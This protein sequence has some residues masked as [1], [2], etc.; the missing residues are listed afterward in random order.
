MLIGRRILIQ[1]N[2][3]FCASICFT[4]V[5]AADPSALFTIDGKTFSQKD[6]TP[7][8]QGRL[9]EIDVNRFKTI[10][11][12]ARQRFVEEKTRAYEKIKSAE[13]PFA[14]E[15]KWLNQS[16][17]PNQPEIDKALENFKD[18]KQLQAL[19]AE[20]K[21]K[22]MRRYLSQQ[23][24]VKVLTEATDKAIEKGEIRISMKA[25]EAPLVVINKSLQVSLGDSKA[26]V[27]VVEF[28]D[29]QCPYCKKLASV[30][31]DV[32]RKHG[33][34]VSWEVRHFPLGFHKQARAASAAVYCASV[35]GKLA[36]AKKWVFDSQ[37]KLPQENIFADMSKALALNS[38]SFEKCRKADTTEKLIQADVQEGE[39]VGVSG[40]PTVFVNGRK[41]Q[42]DIQSV[43]AWDSLINSLVKNPQNPTT[44]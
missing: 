41:F 32:L 24:R 12:L 22:V 23:K 31:Q 25:P 3:F 19:P 36:E 33:K 28:T 37:E 18:E 2:A 20:E 16:F 6:L 10:E 38:D 13:K 17:D 35:Q 1:A 40:T 8:E 42:G 14:A 21:N 26:P 30:T 39:R 11:S 7:S 29:F 44:L 27:R 9:H 34:N 5:F 4:S 43:E 15:E